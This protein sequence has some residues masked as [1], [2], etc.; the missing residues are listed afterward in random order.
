[1]D[2]L[3]KLL[4][5]EQ[6][7]TH[8]EETQ[9]C[10]ISIKICFTKLNILIILVLMLLTWMG[11]QFITFNYGSL[12]A[13]GDSIVG[14]RDKAL[15]KEETLRLYEGLIYDD[16]GKLND[17][18]L[19]VR[20]RADGTRRGADLVKDVPIK[21]RITMIE[22]AYTLGSTNA[23]NWIMEQPEWDNGLTYE[24]KKL[25]IRGPQR[26]EGRTG[27]DWRAKYYE[28]KKHHYNEHH[29]DVTVAQNKADDYEKRFNVSQSKL[30]TL[31]S[32]YWNDPEYLKKVKFEHLN[33]KWWHGFNLRLKE[34]PK[35]EA[36]LLKGNK[37]VNKK[38]NLT[39]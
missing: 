27:K 24:T 2:K 35:V 3:S 26:Y 12:F 29:I 11:T 20:H 1:M 9:A 18:K 25:A 5:E 31:L 32:W 39:K 38:K 23:L 17:A 22:T 33:E 7:E 10:Q 8:F 15:Q 36:H 4:K 34:A 21:D 6:T 14:L 13:S 16:F 30:N 37:I 19:V 28:L